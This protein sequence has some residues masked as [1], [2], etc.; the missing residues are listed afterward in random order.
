MEAGRS[1]RPQ[2]VNGGNDDFQISFQPFG[3]N[4]LNTTLGNL[5]AAAVVGR[6]GPVNL[7]VVVQPLGQRH[8]AELCGSHTGDW[9][10]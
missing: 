1:T 9:S 3:S 8:R 6:V 7:L 2:G 4:K 5:P 10:G